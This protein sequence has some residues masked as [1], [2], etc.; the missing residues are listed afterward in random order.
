MTDSPT[1]S[2]S[3]YAPATEAGSPD[4]EVTA[5]LHQEIEERLRAQLEQGILPQWTAPQPHP[6]MSDHGMTAQFLA[7]P[8]KDAD[9]QTPPVVDTGYYCR[10]FPA[11]ESAPDDKALMMLGAPCGPMDANPPGRPEHRI[12]EQAPVKTPCLSSGAR[13]KES[14]DLKTV[15]AG[16]TYF[17]QFLDHNITFQADA[18]FD[19]GNDPKAN[20][21]YRS[22]RISLEHVYGLGPQTQSF[23]YYD[24]KDNGKFWIDPDRAYDVP[25]N[26]EGVPL[27]ADPRNDNTVITIQLHLAFM[28]FHNAVVD[29][30]IGQVPD[31]KLFAAAKQTVV[32]HYQ[33]LVLHDWLSK[34]IEPNIFDQIQKN[35]GKFFH[36]QPGPITL[37][38]EFTVAGYRLHS[39][40]K[41]RYQLN[42][43]T[44]GHLFHFRKPFSRLSP[45]DRIDWSY[46]FATGERTPQYAKKF[47]GKVVHTFLNMPG[48]IDTPIE[49]LD[50]PVKT[51]PIPGVQPPEEYVPL[52]SIAV[53]NLLRGKAFR[54]PSGQ[55]VAKK[56]IEAYKLGGHP[57]TNEELGLTLDGFG[58][59]APLWYYVMKEGAVAAEG[60]TLGPVGSVLVG[61]VLFG[62]LRADPTSFLYHNE[63]DK[64]HEW[65]PVL[66]AKPGVFTMADMLRVAGV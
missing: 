27:I 1:L 42:H 32:W 15:P 22:G 59:E 4:G 2:T 23:Q 56:V 17:G 24:N 61:E 48:P 40:V 58:S 3:A 28:K 63:H 60:S 53:R 49:W 37:P 55:A 13:E 33:W 62:L 44:E 31:K 57:C 12:S 7:E 19:P 16:Y 54:L 51:M 21:N 50:N 47:N 64:N 10:L 65:K 35:K 46:F 30:L 20:P 66:G 26:D 41:E 18:T 45:D 6:S 36:P 52:R 5:K 9:G 29:M 43:R 39:L 11:S 38:V 14:D 25:R 34:I 8:K